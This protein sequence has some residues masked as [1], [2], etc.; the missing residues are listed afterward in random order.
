MTT[1]EHAYLIGITLANGVMLALSW[2]NAKESVHARDS[3][4][5]AAAHA[6]TDANRADR[7]MQIAHDLHDC[8]RQ[9]VPVKPYTGPQRDAVSF[10]MPRI[11]PE[12]RTGECK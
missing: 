2:V 10:D 3:A 4:N 7:A 12:G 11:D 8:V 1:I 6:H 9:A 5:T